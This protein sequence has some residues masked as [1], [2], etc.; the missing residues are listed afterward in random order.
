MSFIIN[1]Y[2]FASGP[3][4][5][6]LEFITSHSMN[7]T[8]NNYTGFMGFEFITTQAILV[9]HLGRI[10]LTG[11]SASHTVNIL[12]NADGGGWG[13]SLA[14][15]V[16]VDVSSGTVGTWI[17]TALGSPVA[18]ASGINCAILSQ[19]LSGGD[20][21]WDDNSGAGIIHNA[22][23]TILGPIFGDNVNGESF[24]RHLSDNDDAYV[25]PNF[26]Y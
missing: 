6:G 19:E 17:Y 3:S 24:T 12:V 26:K 22:G 25:P 21:F 11:N 8:R 1:P 5:L 16:S 13:G 20:N 23:A 10:R 18:I 4:A 15:S 7:T 9:T 2:L 14:G